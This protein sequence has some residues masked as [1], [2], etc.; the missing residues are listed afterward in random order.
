MKWA[1][2]QEKKA[3]RLRLVR[4]G[5]EGE[6]GKKISHLLFADDTL[7]FYKANKDQVTF[8]SWTLMWFE[9]I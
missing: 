5:G 4:S 2:Q 3:Y 7:I 8:L 9:A 1:L 6:K